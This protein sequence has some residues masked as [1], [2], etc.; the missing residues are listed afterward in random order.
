MAKRNQMSYDDGYPMD[1]APV[2]KKKKK[3][4][5]L[6]RIIRRFFLLVFTVVILAVTA[7]CLVMNLVFNGPSPAA[8]QVL[9]MSL[10]EASATKW[11]PGLFMDDETV[12][13]IRKNVEFEL[14][15]EVSDTS[16][17]VINKDHALSGAGSEFANC[18][19][20]IY[21]EEIS[22][23]TYNAHVMIIQ[24]PS[25]VYMATSTDGKF[26]ESIPGTRI[27]DEIVTEGAIAAINAG[28]FN[29]DGTA[30]TQVGSVP[31]G[32]TIHGG[33]VVSDQYKGLVPEQG[34]CGF[35][36]ENKLVV[37]ETMTAEQAMEQNIRDGCEFGP[38]LIV[39]GV[40]NQ[41]VYSGNSGYN[42][43]TVVG[44]R[45]DGVVIFVCADG[46]QAGSLGAT[47]K[48]MIDI[49]VSY[50]AVNA[51]NMDGGS[52]SVM[53]YNDVDGRYADRDYHDIDSSETVKMVNNYSVLQSKPRRMP[54]FWMVRPASEG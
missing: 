22:G 46:R 8:R 44:Q 28:A 50:G 37:A 43:R 1:A 2:K 53:L 4:G 31:A 14:P 30:G 13:E 15:E 16:S 32:L 11:V 21:I 51:C 42:P 26:S 5:L 41:K 23:A 36:N 33:Q 54:N 20:G 25:R 35:N 9:T 47:Y 39:N 38:V 40:P 6:G 48:D 34:F 49:L 12:A 18:P 17:V 52:S 3:G 24:D 27:T 45:A 7:L 19:D 29:D 10:T